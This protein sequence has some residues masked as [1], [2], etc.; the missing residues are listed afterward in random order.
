M[1]AGF[2]SG[3]GQQAIQGL[4]GQQTPQQR[5]DQSRQ[6]GGILKLRGQGQQPRS[7]LDL[8]PEDDMFPVDRNP[9][10]FPE[11]GNPTNPFQGGEPGLPYT[12]GGQPGMFEP[13]Q[14]QNQQYFQQMHQNM[15][16]M[17]ENMDGLSQALQQIEGMKMPGGQY[18]G[19]EFTP[20]GGGKFGT[21]FGGGFTFG[22]PTRY[23]DRSF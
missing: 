6:G 7:Y 10:P 19:G 2:Y 21:P 17:N 3:I 15:D 9:Q 16:G 5:V 18:R 13:N 1:G 11:P 12:P 8:P 14:E 4:G 20:G 22:Q 23:E